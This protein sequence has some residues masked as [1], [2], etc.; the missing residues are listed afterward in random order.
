MLKNRWTVVFAVA[1]LATAA[2]GQVMEFVPVS[3]T[4]PSTINGNEIVLPAGDVRVQFDAFVSGWGDAPNSPKC[5]ACQVWLLLSSLLGANATPP[6]P[7]VDLGY[8]AQVACATAA[9][10]ASGGCGAFETGFCNDNQPAYELLNVCLD[11]M[12]TPC[13]N[14]GQCAGTPVCIPNPDFLGA[15][16][17]PAAATFI[18]PP[19][20]FA[21]FMACQGAPVTDTGVAKYMGSVRID[22]PGEAAGTY[23]LALNPSSE[24]SLLNDGNGVLIPGLTRIPGTIRL[25]LDC[26]NNGTPDDQ[27][28]ASGT[29]PDCNDNEIPD[30]CEDDCN[31]NGRADECD[32]S[33]QLSSDCNGNGVP[34]ECEPDGD[35][36]HTGALHECDIAS[37]NSSDC[38]L[39]GLPD[40]CQTDC[41]GNG[42]PDSCDLTGGSADCNGN[43]IPDEC[44]S[45]GDCDNNGSQDICDVAAGAPDCNFN[46]IPDECEPDED[47]NTNGVRD[48]CDIGA[49]TEADCNGNNIPDV[50]DVREGSSPDANS[51]G[52]PDEC[53]VVAPAVPFSPHDWQ[54]SRFV[55]FL[56][57]NDQPVAIKVEWI[58]RQ[59]GTTGWDCHA[60]ADC[61][62]GERCNELGSVHLGWVGE[63]FDASTLDFSIAPVGTFT[64]HVVSEPA[65]IDW[66]A[67]DVV[68]IGDCEIA[69]LHRYALSVTTDP[70]G[71][72]FSDPLFLQ[73]ISKADFHFWGD[74]VGH[75]D[76][77]AWTPPNGVVGGV[78]IQAWIFA[79]LSKPAPH[80]TAVDLH[81]DVPNFILNVTD[82]TLVLEGVRGKQYPP[83]AFDNQGTV[84]ECP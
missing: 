10:C 28:T 55:S 1:G 44:E 27:D 29:S 13:A 35:C 42:T 47:C 69:P 14:G 74:M 7:G 33:F 62:L 40:E 8:P 48:I 65:L 60:D 22:V 80:I 32:I 64:S 70:S 19:E 75:F 25:P 77:T 6:N 82:L 58:Q 9:D 51:N 76:G 54:K 24:R 61:M 46:E 26:N 56:P 66:T 39:N 3:S 30:E 68:H 34:D 72:L 57:N 78:D 20:H 83:L 59:C 81:P 36:N 45:N 21:W 52:V 4:G 73:T 49:F 84:A 16:C 23:T 67:F 15:A 53:D 41:N 31:E 63:P 17:A 38:D 50:C 5:G 71:E 37:G 12:T 79:F 43:G 18:D 2:T 11:D